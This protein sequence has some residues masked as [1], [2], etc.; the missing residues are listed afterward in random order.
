M[1]IF[2]STVSLLKD[3]QNWGSFFLLG[4][5][6]IL[7]IGNAIMG[8]KTKKKT[9]NINFACSQELKSEILA[10]AKNDGETAPGTWCRQLIARWLKTNKEKGRNDA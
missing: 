9:S 10:A 4:F 1:S 8:R 7:W 2:N 6:F 5:A 3:P